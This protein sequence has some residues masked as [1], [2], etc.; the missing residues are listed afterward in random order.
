MSMYNMEV[1]KVI[2]HINKKGYTNVGLQFPE[3]LKMQVV[4]IARQIEEETDATVII[5]GDPCFGACDVCDKKM[6]GIVDMIVHYA[7]TPLPLKYR[8]PVMFIEAYSSINLKKSLDKALDLLED[9]S[10][11][12]LATT[13]Q[14]L[15]LLGEIKDYL[16]DNG[17]EIV[18]GSSSKGTTKGQVLGCNFSSI[19]NLDA[20]IYL[21]IGSGKFHPVGIHLFTKAPVIAVDPYNGE[22]KEISDYADRILRVRFARI[23]KA[24]SVK[25]WGILVS[26]KEGQYRMGLAKEIKKSLNDENMEAY[27]ILVDKISPEILLPYM[28]L[29]GFVVTACP[30]IAI[31]DSAM[32]KKPLITPKELE[33]VLNKRK[34][35]NY[36]LDEILFHERYKN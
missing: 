5:S 15:H 30:R 34:W 12:A 27:I 19:K 11:I 21:F 1:E 29:E 18:I 23:V 9:Y 35:E 32:Y 33:I 28:E 7:H 25:K 8:V 16:E 4:S 14:H 31:D 13:T 26:S 3:G 2:N 10:K 24:K 6:E 20:E 17:K 22:A 36:E